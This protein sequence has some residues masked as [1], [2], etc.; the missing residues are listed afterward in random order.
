MEIRSSIHHYTYIEHSRSLKM[1][2]DK[3]IKLVVDS[4]GHWK[5]DHDRIEE[6]GFFAQLVYFTLYLLN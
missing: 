4:M 2:A 5:S 6:L 3:N 1:A